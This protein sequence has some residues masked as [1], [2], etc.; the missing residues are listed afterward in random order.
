LRTYRGVCLS[1]LLLTTM[2]SLPARAQQSAALIGIAKYSRPDDLIHPDQVQLGP[3]GISKLQPLLL[4]LSYNLVNASL[5]EP[6]HLSPS[7]SPQCSDL[8]ALCVKPFLALAVRQAPLTPFRIN[9]CKS[10]SKQMTLT[11]FRITTYGK[12]GRGVPPSLHL[13]VLRAPTSAPSVLSPLPLPTFQIVRCTTI[14]E[15]R[16]IGFRAALRRVP[17]QRS[18]RAR[19]CRKRN[20]IQFRIRG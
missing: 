20:G 6:V 11:P 10:V 1:L 18:L 5:A 7:L 19:A 14:T 15:W 13:R 9:T 3:C 8:S 16:K 17:N 2:F 12:Q 4:R